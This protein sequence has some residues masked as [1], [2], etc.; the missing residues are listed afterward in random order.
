MAAIMSWI[1]VLNCLFDKLFWMEVF[2]ENLWD[3]FGIKLFL[4]SCQVMIVM[5]VVD[6]HVW[7]QSLQNSLTVACVTMWYCC[8]A[9]MWTLFT[10]ALTNWEDNNWPECLCARVVTRG[11]RLAV[12]PL[13][14]PDLSDAWGLSG[15]P[16]PRMPCR[17]RRP[18]SMLLTG[19]HLTVYRLI[20]P[21]W[22]AVILCIVW[23]CRARQDGTVPDETRRCLII[24]EDYH[25]A[26]SH[27]MCNGP[28][29]RN[30]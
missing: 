20:L 7:H 22:N 2:K 10:N 5:L 25:L 3:F 6:N 18:D 29:G 30:K 28:R 9:L 13:T 14:M 19:Y 12:Y 27:L 16:I 4:L 21:Y 8:M 17:D 23:C 15:V 26:A 24:P 11:I 1:V